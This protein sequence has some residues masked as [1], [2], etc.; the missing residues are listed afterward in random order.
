MDATLIRPSASNL[1]IFWMTP[2]R[3]PNVRVISWTPMFGEI[4]NSPYKENRPEF[5]T[6]FDVGDW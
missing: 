2:G 1:A 6:A 5:E 3:F 4:R